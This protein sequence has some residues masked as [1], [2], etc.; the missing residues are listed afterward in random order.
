[1]GKNFGQPIVPTTGIVPGSGQTNHLARC[2][3]YFILEKTTQAS[4]IVRV[5]QY[6]D[7]VVVRAE[8]GPRTVHRALTRAAKT[9]LQELTEAELPASTKTTIVA[10]DQEVAEAVQ[11]SIEQAGLRIT[12]AR[13]AKD[14]GMDT[15]LA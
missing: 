2:M 8:G 7:D 3:L 14:L 12:I 1:M 10:T 15:T 9:M 4:P 6:V 11:R 5:R 13:Q